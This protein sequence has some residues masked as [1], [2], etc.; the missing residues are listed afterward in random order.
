[1]KLILTIIMTLTWNLGHAQ[2]NSDVDLSDQVDNTDIISEEYLLYLQTLT[3]EQLIQ[4]TIINI[5]AASEGGGWTG[6]GG[7]F[8]LHESNIWYMG[9]KEI[10]Y[11]IGRA[12]DYPLSEIELTRLVNQSFSQWKQ[13]FNHY[14][15]LN[16]N[17][18]VNNG[19]FSV[20]F[21]DFKNRSINFNF[22]KVECT[23]DAKGEIQEIKNGL[24]FLFGVSNSV[25]LKNQS[26]AHT[27][28][29]VSLRKLY[30]HKNYV[31]TGFIWLKDFSTE[32]NKIKHLLLHEIGHILGM[33]HDSVFVMDEDIAYQLR[34][35][36]KY[37]RDYFGDIESPAWMYRLEEGKTYNLTA[38]RGRVLP[39]KCFD[40]DYMPNKF[41]P[42]Y[43]KK[44]FNLKERGCH[45]LVLSYVKDGTN[46]SQKMF[47]LQMM[48]LKGD[49]SREFR[50]VL[51][52]S[53]I[54]PREI[55]LQVFFLSGK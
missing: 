1:M 42:G 30:D 11:C 3:N 44:L 43:V 14:G 49:V 55:H 18:N 28:L 2:D 51:K 20:Q 38:T 19:K 12:N 47:K 34:D 33:K 8:H 4:E 39:T 36:Q 50:G 52:A 13:F 22:K 23:L 5:E 37:S 6:T 31:S 7:N 26:T 35:N 29:G 10:P 53:V 32:I 40:S 25:V 45:K 24:V 21:P 46:A 16:K 54:K 48:N 27:Q 9:N 17:I 41:L 15:M